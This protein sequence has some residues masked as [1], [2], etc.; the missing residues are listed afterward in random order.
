MFPIILVFIL[1]ESV[2]RSDN[3]SSR[4][5]MNSRIV[6]ICNNLEYLSFNA[7]ASKPRNLLYCIREAT[8]KYL[9]WYRYLYSHNLTFPPAVRMATKIPAVARKNA[10]QPI[11]FLL[12]YWLSRSSNVNYFHVTFRPICDF[13]LVI[14]SYLG[15]VSHRLGT[16]HLLHIKGQ[17]DTQLVL[18]KVT[19]M[20]TKRLC[21]VLYLSNTW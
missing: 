18:S 15:T 21:Y 17:T 8:R 1:R 6:Y 2:D 4:W 16:I 20:W 5:N 3:P 10:L 7:N 9:S 14:H 12:Q 11:Q 13:L 19:E